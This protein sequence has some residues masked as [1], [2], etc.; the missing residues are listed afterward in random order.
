MVRRLGFGARPDAAASLPTVEDAI[1]ESLD[2]TPH[3][4]LDPLPA[5]ADPQAARDR[6]LVRQVYGRWL[7]ATIPGVRPIEQ[8]LVWFWH[9][10]FAID[11]RKVGF[12]NL[13]DRYHLTLRQHA[14]GNFADLLRAMASDPAMLLYLDGAR[15]SVD[16]LNENFGREVLELHTLGHGNYTEADVLAAARAFSGWVVAVPNGRSDRL[17]DRFDAA[18]WDAV[19]VPFRHDSGTKT[20]LG[21]TGALDAAAAVDILVD[22][23]TTATTVSQSLFRHLVGTEPDPTTLE[24]LAATLRSTYEVMDL[25]EAIVATPEFTADGAIRSKIRSPLEQ[26]IGVVQASGANP[27]VMRAVVET[28]GDIGYV[29]FRAPNPA[30]YPEG[31][32]LL[33]PHRLVRTFDL[34]AAAPPEITGLDARQMMERLGIFDVSATTHGVLERTKD[35]ALRWALAVNSPEHHLV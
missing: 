12:A 32:R 29:P 20:L 7:E 10:H 2:L 22:H 35:G 31:D 33:S 21:V 16:A 25:V 15:S 19:F 11:L 4:S 17:L 18:P 28:V 5:P 24:S 8:R 1:A 9:D 6:T 14:T 23:P 3:Q 34:S 30:G 27:A 13:V 26:A